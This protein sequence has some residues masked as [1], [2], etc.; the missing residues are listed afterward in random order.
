MIRAGFWI[1][2]FIYFRYSVISFEKAKCEL[3]IKQV[4]TSFTII[5]SV[6]SEINDVIFVFGD[7]LQN[8]EFG[9]RD[10]KK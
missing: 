5:L 4:T 8:I 9:I 6:S 7:D 3:L 10:R 2:I 1:P